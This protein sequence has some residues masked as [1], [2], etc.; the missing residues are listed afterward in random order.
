VASESS[1]VTRRLL[2]RDAPPLPLFTTFTTFTTATSRVV[3]TPILNGYTRILLGARGCVT[4]DMYS[5]IAKGCVGPNRP[6]RG[7]RQLHV[8]HDDGFARIVYKSSSASRMRRRASSTVRPCVA[9]AC[10][11]HGGDPPARLVS[12]IGHAIRLH[13]FNHPF[14]GT[15]PSRVRCGAA[16]RA[17]CLQPYEPVRTSHTGRIRMRRCEPCCR[18]STQPKD[19]RMRRR[20]FAVTKCRIADGCLMCLWR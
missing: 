19:L 9:A 17:R 1:E 11:G 5:R 4:G 8:V 10:T 13:G 15:A 14:R 12:L 3:A 2:Q 16:D 18:L 20:S 7:T 6:C